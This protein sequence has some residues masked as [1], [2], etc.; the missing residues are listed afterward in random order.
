MEKQHRATISRHIT[1]NKVI[2]IFSL[3]RPGLICSVLHL[4]TD[5]FLHHTLSTLA[6][7][8]DSIS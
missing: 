3:Q 5:T 1:L 2:L 7:T 8:I 4:S 6:D